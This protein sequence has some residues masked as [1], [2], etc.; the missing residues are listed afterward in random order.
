MEFLKKKYRPWSFRWV[1]QRFVALVR[2]RRLPQL[3]AG[4]LLKD[5]R[6]TRR[7]NAKL[8]TAGA[9]IDLQQ[10]HFGD[11]FFNFTP[12]IEYQPLIVNEGADKSSLSCLNTLFDH[13]YVL[14]LGRRIDRRI[15][16][17][18]KLKKYQIQAE[19][20]EAVDGYTPDNQEEFYEY[21][22]KPVGSEGSH[23]LEHSLRKKLLA[24]PGAWGYLKTWRNVLLDAKKNHYR[25]FVCFDDDIL[26][27]KD[28]ESRL[29][30]AMDHIPQ[31]W[32]VIYLGA[33]Q[34][35]WKVPEHLDHPSAYKDKP[36]DA[37]YYHP[38]K[39][40]GSFAM[41]IEA[42]IY[43]E[44]LE[45]IAPMNCAF[46]SGPLRS[47]L[48]KYNRQC[49]VLTPNL[50]IADV[51]QSDIMVDRE[52]E[53]MAVK[54]RWNLGDYDYPFRKE[55]VSVIMPAFNAEKTIEKSIR[56]ILAQHYGELEMIVADDGSTDRTAEIVERLAKEDSRVKLVRLGQNQGCYPARN[57]AL[58]ASKGK[59]IAIQDSDDISL[60]SRLETQLVPLLLGKAQFTVSRIF[61]SRCTV[62]ELDISDQKE[63][64]RT[65]LAKREKNAAGNY[66]YHDRPV[67][68]FMTSMFTR[69]LFEE[70]GLFWEHRFGA[71]AEILERA[72]FLKAGILLSKEDG[73]IHSYLMDRKSIPGLYERI[74]KVLL[75]SLEMTG[76]NIT[77]RHSKQE[78]EA[79]QELW[80]RKFRGDNDYIYPQF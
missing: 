66:D 67:I 75:I 1:V 13:V 21:Y 6:H 36:A 58:R 23:P 32:K 61:R 45:Q 34:Y 30:E 54:V 20:V 38:L 31:D 22:R 65:V 48:E 47:M 5:Y 4:M 51:N 10:D 3:P 25:N 73:T 41:V 27:H 76:D 12:S 72:L 9:T 74:D 49:F 11:D 33:S 39:T 8:K 69:E 55:L 53:K 19:I 64:I 2:E 35:L 18:Q 24:S 59:Y 71:D 80:R 52:Q 68:G 26:F 57:A 70:Y 16:M 42:S 37:P 56:S 15:E 40:D 79:F 7:L 29:A 63:M 17:I 28:F 44:L 77:N 50:V 62:E 14:N 43:D 60:S 78:K 46:D